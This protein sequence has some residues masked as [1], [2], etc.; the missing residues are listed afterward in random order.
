MIHVPI[1]PN[2]DEVYI[3]K[4]QEDIESAAAHLLAGRCADFAAY[5]AECAKINALQN[6]KT[7]FQELVSR[8]Q[9]E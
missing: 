7:T 1:P 4:L 3:N 8:L 6:A 5:K 9:G 2:F